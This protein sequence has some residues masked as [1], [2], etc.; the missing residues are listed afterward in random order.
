[1]R[2]EMFLLTL[3]PFAAPC[4]PV[5]NVQCRLTSPWTTNPLLSLIRL[6][7]LS[8]L[9][10]TRYYQWRPSRI[11]NTLKRFRLFGLWY[12]LHH[13]GT[14]DE[15]RRQTSCIGNGGQKLE[16]RDEGI[17]TEAPRKKKTRS[18]FEA[19]IMNEVAFVRWL[20]LPFYLYCFNEIMM[21]SIL[22]ILHALA[23]TLKFNW[24]R[25]IQSSPVHFVVYKKWCAVYQASIYLY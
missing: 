19:L 1:M 16:V 2:T 18:I 10:S 24:W 12:C 17:K 22:F 14:A 7:D 11:I 21:L 23:M 8:L 3:R 20:D 9:P 5:T 6:I 4:L 13:Q 15:S 25:K